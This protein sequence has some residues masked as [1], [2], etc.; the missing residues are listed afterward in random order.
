MRNKCGIEPYRVQQWIIN[1]ILPQFDPKKSSLG[2][3]EA[4][5]IPKRMTT[6][7]YCH[8]CFFLCGGGGGLVVGGGAFLVGGGNVCDDMGGVSTGDEVMLTSPP[9]LAHCGW[10]S[11]E[12]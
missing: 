9:K 12:V 6:G 1:S 11:G 2:L 5:I 4:K 10:W 7:I 3:L 8:D